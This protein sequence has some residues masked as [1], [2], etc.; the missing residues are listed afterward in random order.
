MFLQLEQPDDAFVDA[1]ED[2]ADALGAVATR[3]PEPW[4]HMM[5]VD[6]LPAERADELA[7]LPGVARTLALH[8]DRPLVDRARLGRTRGVRIGD[9]VVG[10]DEFVV[11]AGPCS[12]DTRDLLLETGAAVRDAG[13]AVLRAGAHKPRTS[14]WEF[15]GLGDP[16]VSLLRHVATSLGLPVVTEVMSPYAVDLMVDEVDMFQVG[17]RNMQNYPL[18]RALGRQPRPVLLKRGAGCTLSEWLLAAE[19][20]LSGG[21]EDV[22]LCERGIRT[23]ESANR[24]TLDLATAILAREQ[25]CLPVIVDPSHATG[26]PAL[27]APLA[28][29]AL[30]AGLDGAII[31]VHAQPRAALSDA[32]QALE[33]AA[34]V[35]VMR[36]LRALAPACGRTVRSASSPAPDVS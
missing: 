11:F 23:F 3:L 36:R 13:A 6:G 10:G 16:G 26:R 24:N 30:A 27:V 29:A 28:A 25:S 9:A 5:R 14:P 19:Y 32:A 22:V 12:I 1:I 21:N 34:F 4:S 33:P 8:P 31:E 17:A 7:R 15:Q 2:A 20:V 35:E 18:L